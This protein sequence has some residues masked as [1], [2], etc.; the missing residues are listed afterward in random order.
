MDYTSLGVQIQKYA[1]R[2]DAM[3]IEQIPNFIIQAMS[4]IYSEA[5]SLGFEIKTVG[6]LVENQ[7]FIG[8]PANWKETIS[9]AIINNTE[10]SYLLPRSEEFGR[11]YW[12]MSTQTDFPLFYS[13]SN[14]SNFLL[15]PTPNSSYPVQLIYRGLPQFNAEAPENFLTQRYPNLLLYACMVEA[16][17]FLKDDE[18]VP[19]WSSFYDRELQNVNRDLQITYVDRTSKRDAN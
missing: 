3:F 4:R 14:Y 2:T 19:V 9:F 18:R 8:K 12:P 6:Y 17:P 13:D 5:K 16:T 15:F 11:T 10:F 1:N 7:A